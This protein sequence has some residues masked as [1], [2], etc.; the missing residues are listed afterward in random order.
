MQLGAVAF[1]LTETVFRK[2]GA[3]VTHHLIARDFRNH[4]GGSNREADAIAINDCRLRKWKWEHRQ[5]IDQDMVRLQGEG[6]E[7]GAHRF[8]GRA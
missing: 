2:L 8:V 4:A 1:V 3:E 7:R 5:P 6:D